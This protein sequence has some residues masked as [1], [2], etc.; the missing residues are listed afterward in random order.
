[1]GQYEKAWQAVN[2]RIAK[3]QD[4]YVANQDML[5]V[6][7]YIG[8]DPEF[9]TAARLTIEKANANIAGMQQKLFFPREGG[10]PDSTSGRSNRLVSRSLRTCGICIVSDQRRRDSRGRTTTEKTN[11][12]ERLF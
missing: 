9:R 2:E 5:V 3:L 6:D 11:V 1:M 8:N 10:E 4:E 12:R 7:G